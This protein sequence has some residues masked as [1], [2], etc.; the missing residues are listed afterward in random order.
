MSAV[1]KERIDKLLLERGMAETDARARALVMSGVVLV[2]DRR[3]EKASEKFP[4]D[5]T[6]RVKGVDK[7][8]RYVGRGGLK[9]EAA[10]R[11][12]AIDP[13]G[14]NCIDIG[15]STGG[16]TDCLLQ[17]GASRVTSV[18]A[19]TNQLVW[20]LRTD[21][22]VEV[23]ERTNAR[24][25]S[26]DEF[27]LAF[28]LAVVDVSFISVTKILPAVTS[29]LVTT[30]SIIALIKPQFEVRRGE[31]GEGGIVRE[32]KKHARVVNEV[33]TFAASLGL[34]LKGGIESPI[35]GAQGNR[36]FLVWYAK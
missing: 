21:P 35:L 29:L 7:A 4:P 30:G 16:F 12:F 8:L 31:V 20:S 9:L 36:E 33:N 26:P 13:T 15:S 5:A 25:L 11:E 34:T 18:D 32:A 3:V 1:V 10:L 2:D 6:I 17:H 28:D 19:G 24:E 14:K 22:R 27:T 23:R